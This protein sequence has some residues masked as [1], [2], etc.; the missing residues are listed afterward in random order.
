MLN[1]SALSAAKDRKRNTALY[2]EN[3]RFLSV[4]DTCREKT[5]PID[6]HTSTE[7]KRAVFMTSQEETGLA[8][9]HRPAIFYVSRL[10]SY[11]NVLSHF[12]KEAF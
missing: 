12:I 7:K 9:K 6:T 1:I 2:L 11:L 4:K 3:D 8:D 5:S 10:T